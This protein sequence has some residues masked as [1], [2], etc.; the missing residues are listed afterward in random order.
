M[1]RCQEALL[2]VTARQTGWGSGHISIM[3]LLFDDV[4]SGF[5]LQHHVRLAAWRYVA[6]PLADIKRLARDQVLWVRYL[7]VAAKPAVALDQ[8]N[9]AGLQRVADDLNGSSV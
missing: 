6:R 2:I 5:R 3:Q 8:E 4:G 1:T 9:V 7:M